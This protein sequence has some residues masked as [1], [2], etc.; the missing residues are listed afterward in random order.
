MT[1]HRSPGPL[2]PSRGWPIAWPT[3]VY[4]IEGLCG[5]C[6]LLWDRCLG[7]RVP[8]PKPIPGVHTCGHFPRAFVRGSGSGECLPPFPRPLTGE[9]L[10]HSLFP[11]FLALTQACVLAATSRPYLVDAA[12]LRP[13]RLDRLVYCGVPGRES[14]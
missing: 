10:P 4:G 11:P 13:G 2:R 3:E 14:R 1:L 6:F 12:L 5:V 7:V 9:R 8:H